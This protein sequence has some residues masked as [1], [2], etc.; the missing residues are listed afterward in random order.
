MGQQQKATG[1][2]RSG[3]VG[4]KAGTVIVVERHIRVFPK[5]CPICGKVFTG[6]KVKKLV[7]SLVMLVT[8]G[9]EISRHT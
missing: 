7:V 6:L 3:P 8:L 4:G 1:G 2:H 5:K 9:V